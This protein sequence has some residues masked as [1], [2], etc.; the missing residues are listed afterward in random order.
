MIQRLEGY[1]ETCRERL[2]TATRNNTDNKRTNRMAITRKQKWEEKQLCEHFKR[3]LTRETWWWVSKGNLQKETE[4]IL[5]PAQNNA[6]STNHIKASTYKTQQISKCRLCGDRNGTINHIISECRKLAKKEYNT[7]H[8]S[9]GKVVYWEL[10][11]KFKFDH[12]NKWYMHNPESVLENETNKL[13]YD[14][15]I[16]TDRLISA[17]RPNLIITKKKKKDLNTRGLCCLG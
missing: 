5:V 14:F 6:I 1:I 10:C 15:D 7:I 8:E 4:S 9:E 17:R 13:L 16:Q 12:M 2:I 11:K 3:H